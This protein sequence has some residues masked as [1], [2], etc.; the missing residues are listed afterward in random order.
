[1]TWKRAIIFVVVAVWIIVCAVSVFATELVAQPR[2]NAPHSLTFSRTDIERL[3]AEVFDDMHL[4]ALLNIEITNDN[5]MPFSSEF[6]FVAQREKTANFSHH[7]PS[8]DFMQ[9]TSLHSSVLTQFTS[10]AP[11]H[12]VQKRFKRAK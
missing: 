10:K 5:T 8:S 11:Y 12:D 7:L 9:E 3:S 4:T 1:M 2:E 6:S